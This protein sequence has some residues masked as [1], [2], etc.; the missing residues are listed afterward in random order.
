M[1]ETEHEQGRGRGRGRH[2]IWSRLWAV[3]TGPDAGL[4]LTDREIMTWAEVRRL[5]NWA[6]QAPLVLV[7]FSEIDGS[8]GNSI[9]NS[10]RNYFTPLLDPQY[11]KNFLVFIYFWERER[12]WMG[13]GQR[14]R[15]RHRVRSRPQ[16]P[17]CQPRAQRGAWTHKP[18][19]HDVSRSQTLKR[20]SHPGAP[21]PYHF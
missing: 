8:Y 20:L 1:R 11:L 4:E 2:R 13:K 5:T 12:A 6:T 19:D 7:L 18:R 17:S 3:R 21:I 9:F 10:L 14:E 15:G 16:A